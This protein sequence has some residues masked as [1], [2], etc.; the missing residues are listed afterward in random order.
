VNAKAASKPESTCIFKSADLGSPFACSSRCVNFVFKHGAILHCLRRREIGSRQVKVLFDSYEPGLL[1]SSN[2]LKD[3]YELEH[4]DQKVRSEGLS[5][6]ASLPRKSLL[7]C[8]NVHPLSHM[9]ACRLGSASARVC[10]SFKRDHC[11]EAAASCQRILHALK[12]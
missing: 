4:K 11:N 6:A 5:S 9:T 8:R 12:L 2:L 10:S 3:V 7:Y 1:N